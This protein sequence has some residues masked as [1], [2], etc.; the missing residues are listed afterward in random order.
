MIE[1]KNRYTGV[2]LMT[3]KSANL[4]GA[5]LSGASLSCANL[6]G[7]DLSGANLSCADLSYDIISVIGIGS[8]RRMTTYHVQQDKVWCGC[9]TGTLKEFTKRVEIAH[10]DNPKHLATYRAAIALFESAKK[11]K[12]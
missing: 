12:S 9:F 6:S 3:I 2:I 5:D 1:I 7:A 11:G 4:S 10:K 8:V